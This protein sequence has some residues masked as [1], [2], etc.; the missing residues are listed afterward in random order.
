MAEESVRKVALVTG[1]GRGLGRSVALRLARDGYALALTARSFEELQETRRLSD[2]APRDALIVLADLCDD[3]APEQVFGT[4]LD[5]FGHLDVLI[6]AAQM[7]GPMPSL[8]DLE[9]MNQDSLPM[10]NLR[11]PI[12]LALMAARQMRKKAVG[13]TIVNFVHSANGCDPVTAAISAGILAFSETAATAWHA[14]QIR[15]AAIKVASFI[16]AG[17]QTHPQILEAGCSQ[18]RTRTPSHATATRMASQVGPVC[19]FESA[20]EDAMAFV[21]ASHDRHPIAVTPED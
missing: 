15:V 21:R 13:G 5:H 3:D 2:L 11:A 10:V 6:N 8:S 1:A 7:T 9:D 4:A 14:D 19:G 20:A 17:A 18:S 12:G 16:A